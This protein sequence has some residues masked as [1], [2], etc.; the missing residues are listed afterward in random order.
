M[1]ALAV[2]NQFVG[3]NKTSPLPLLPSVLG[4]IFHCTMKNAPEKHDRAID[5]TITVVRDRLLVGKMGD[6]VKVCK[7]QKTVLFAQDY[8]TIST[9]RKDKRN[10]Q[11]PIM[12][13]S[14]VKDK[15][16]LLSH[17]RITPGSGRSVLGTM[18]STISAMTYRPPSL[19]KTGTCYRGPFNTDPSRVFL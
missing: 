17:Y 16:Y 15:T 13:G 3:K 12:I 18:S 19:G 4:Y 5:A 8:A 6:V 2:S 14:S 1:L 11:R 7:Q 10:I 9:S